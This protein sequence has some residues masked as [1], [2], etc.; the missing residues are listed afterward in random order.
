MKH[1]LIGFSE[2][3]TERRNK[4][5]QSNKPQPWIVRKLTIGIVVALVGWAWYVYIGR[6]CVPLIRGDPS[7]SGALGGKG[8]GSEFGYLLRFLNRLEIRC[9]DCDARSCVPGC[10][11]LP[12]AHVLV[13]LHQSTL[14]ILSYNVNP[15]QM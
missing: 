13:G 12:R 10:V 15:S 8:L 7:V 2:A 14:F 5:F 9:A 11:L 6:F 1:K 4:R 3:L